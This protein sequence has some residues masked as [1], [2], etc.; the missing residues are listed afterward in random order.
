M[1]SMQRIR[2][3]VEGKPVDRI[4]LAAWYHMPLLDHVARTLPRAR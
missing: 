2:A 4:G 3:M 1:N